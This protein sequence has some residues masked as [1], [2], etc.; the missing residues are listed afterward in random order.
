MNS[1]FIAELIS[2]FNYLCP[3]ITWQLL[4]FQVSHQELMR[5]KGMQKHST[6]L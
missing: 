4:V 3:N 1:Y 2:V 5:T 6:A